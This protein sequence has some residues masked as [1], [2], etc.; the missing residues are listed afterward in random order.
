MS[1]AAST[2]NRA[3]PNG[4]VS[5]AGGDT[6]P[7]INMVGKGFT[8]G[9]ASSPIVYAGDYG[10]PLCY[11][12]S[13][14]GVW[15]LGTD[16]TGMIVVCDRGDNARVDKARAVVEVN[17]AGFVLANNAASADALVGDA[18]VIPGVH[19][20]YDDGV[21]LKPG[22]QPVPDIWQLSLV[23]R[24][25]RMQVMQISWLTSVPVDRMEQLIS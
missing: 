21:V 25:I 23:L 10:N 9:L 2:H 6:T 17:A 4:L 3:Y 5:M 18:Y 8:A 15:D 20:T 7:P 19:L 22:L 13:E 16:F 1:T 12:A 24:E 14:G 11:M